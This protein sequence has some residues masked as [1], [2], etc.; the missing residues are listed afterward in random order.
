MVNVPL[1][2][3]VSS[4]NHSL[5]TLSAFVTN[6]SQPPYDKPLHSLPAVISECPVSH[7]PTV[8]SCGAALRVCFE[9]KSHNQEMSST[10]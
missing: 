8:D 3:T 9:G 1:K 5:K 7:I 10:G 4:N 6:V 2:N